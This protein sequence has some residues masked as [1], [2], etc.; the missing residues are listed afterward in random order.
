M[1]YKQFELDIFQEDAITA[2]DNNHSVVVSAPTGSGKTLI[3]DFIIDKELKTGKRVVYTAPIK[4]LSNQK[5][6]D[7]CKE[8]GEQNI[9]LMTGDTVINPHAQVVIMT[10]EI[11]R[12]M[13]LIK[14]PEIMN[15]SYVIFD[16]IHYINDIERGV[17]WEESIIFA[18]DH[19]RFLCLSATIP[20]ARQFANWIES[21]KQHTV[22]VVIH[23]KRPVPLEQL[24][25]DDVLGITTLDRIEKVR[26][27]PRD[28]RDKKDKARR[29]EHI[30]LIEDLGEDKLPC[31]FFC[32][33]RMA[34]QRNAVELAKKWQLA[35]KSDPDTTRMIINKLQTAPPEVGQLETTRIL[36]ELLPRG[37]G[38]HH[39]GLIPVLKEIVEELFGQGK[40]RVLYAT[41]TFA[42]GINM[43]AKT[44]CF[45]SFRKFNGL[46]FTLLTS[47]EY[48]QM[49][50]RAGRRGIDTIG[51]AIAMLDRER[52]ELKGIRERTDRDVEPLVSQ[53]KLS[54]NTVLNLVHNHVPDE[55]RKILQQSFYTY[56]N[57]KETM[58]QT[59]Y[60]KKYE[61][62]KKMGYIIDDKL[63]D[64]GFFASRMYC[65]ELIFT[66]LFATDLWQEF[67]DYQ[68]TLILACLVFESRERTAFKNKHVHRDEKYV[69]KRTRFL[70]GKRSDSIYD[71][72][73]LIFPLFQQKTFFDLLENTNMAEGDIIRFFNQILDRINQVIRASE[74]SELRQRMRTCFDLMRIMLEK[75]C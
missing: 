35:G 38:F 54:Y 8:Y 4:A 66:E 40:I 20:N 15:V 42:V 2:I 46:N 5:F 41:E 13:V 74:N 47:K 14:D 19:V 59:S 63:T 44:V 60:K 57:R 71:I 37:I 26:H 43:P 65:D 32:F 1:Q 34:C 22:D 24:F 56:I 28:R 48:F 29:Q 18:P 39:A 45:E 61:K 25:Y 75:V 21:I 23:T 64:K 33:S 10:T 51:Y 17:V 50:G 27:I 12:N 55:R 7:F 11:F 53:F 73:A 36:R 58:I 16:E 72:S 9:G 67:S 70:I 3:A 62:L 52:A 30:R 68:L 31:L 6:K 49:A 69:Y